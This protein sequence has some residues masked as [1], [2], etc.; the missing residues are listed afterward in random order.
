MFNIM[1]GNKP[2]K[3]MANM[4]LPQASLFLGIIP[5]L[6][7]LYF[8]LKGYEGYYKDK[9]IFLTF[10]I[11]IILGFI[12]AFVL[13]STFRGLEGI[14]LFSILLAF[15]DQLF[16]TIVLNFSKVHK[17]GEATIYGLSLG[18]GFG[19]SFT[20]FLIILVSSLITSDLYVLSLIAI[21]SF[22]IILFHGATA[23]YIGYGIYVGK[24]KKY[25]LISIL[26]QIPFSLILGL[27]ILYSHPNKINLQLGLVICLIIYGGIIYW[28]V[29]T[30]IMPQ[31]LTQNKKRKRKSIEPTVIK[32]E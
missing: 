9:T 14:I 1:L 4:M 5:A 30:K 16:K 8:C 17:K 2:W 22:G 24:L 29:I 18:L 20:P 21:G 25:L 15:F 6:I 11:G 19:S 10:V 26:L 28:Y 23:A 32:K 12:A 13:F 27:A 7:L 31:I 3:K